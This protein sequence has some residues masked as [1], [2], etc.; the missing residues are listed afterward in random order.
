[1]KSSK[2]T[3]RTGVFVGQ[4]VCWTLGRGG[5]GA[6]AAM[7]R[8]STEIRQT[9][10]GLEEEGVGG[11]G[12]VWAPKVSA[13]NMARSDFPNGKF[14]PTMVT[15]VWGWWGGGSSYGCQPFSYIPASDRQP[16]SYLSFALCLLAF[17]L[18]FVNA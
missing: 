16:Q 15:L 12:G 6:Y 3:V 9:R 14:F 5:G 2:N 10:D 13:P 11:G 7:F 4:G 17:S 1:M 18:Y 8:S